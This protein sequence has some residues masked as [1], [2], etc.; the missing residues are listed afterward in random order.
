MKLVQLVLV[1]GAFLGFSF[2]SEVSAKCLTPDPSP[3]YLS[4]FPAKPVRR[5]V[6]N[7]LFPRQ[8]Q[9][10]TVDVYFHIAST[11]ANAGKVTEQR[12][13]D[14]FQVLKNAY[15]P[16]GIHMLLRNTSWIVD[17]I[18][19]TGFYQED[20]S[21]S[22]ELFEQ[23]FAHMQRTRQGSHSTLN[24][25]FYTDMPVGI[26]GICPLPTF[27]T[28]GDEWFYRDGCQLHANTMPGG[29]IAKYLGNTAI[30]EAGHWFGLLHTFQG[31]C[32]IYGDGVMDTPPQA[33]ASVGCPVGRDS[34]PGEEGLDPIHN[35]MDYS[36]DECTTEF[37]PGQSELM[38]DS[39]A[40]FRAGI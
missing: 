16:Y 22:D 27:V 2:A 17:D 25:Y 23:W 30:H 35:Y 26:Q 14:Q 6:N 8:S 20:G 4:L 32:S 19:G 28:P 7:G 12:V 9:N 18:T 11:F 21:M 1:A 10:L 29:D 36:D 39:F 5:S 31:K 13:A 3:E 37:T 24:L 15:S 38:H 40:R 33:S 34:C